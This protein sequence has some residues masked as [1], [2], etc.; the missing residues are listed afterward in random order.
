MRNLPHL[1]VGALLAAASWTAL[2]ERTPP[3]PQALT[4]GPSARVIVQFKDGAS[5]LRAHALSAGSDAFSQQLALSNRAQSLASR[6]GLALRSGAGISERSQVVHGPA[7]MTSQALADQLAADPEVEFAVPDHRMRRLATP[8]DTL[9]PALG[10]GARGPASAQWYLRTPNAEHPASINAQVAWD[11]S[12]GDNVIVAV[13]DTGVRPGHDDL[14]GKLVG[15][16]D[17]V[18]ND[19]G[20]PGAATGPEPSISNDGTGRD[21][22]PSDPGDWLTTAE[23]NADP[24]F[25]QRDVE[26][27]CRASPSSWHG[28]Q[29]AGIVGAATDNGAGMAGTG[30][31]VR[32]M[33]VRVLGKCFGYTSD[34][35]AAMRWA[36]GLSVPNIPDNPNPAH[37]IN[38]SLGGTATCNSG[39]SSA[40]ADITARGVVV[41]AAAGNSAGRA[42][43]APANCAGV[44]GVAGVR[45]VG[46]KVGFSDV[47]PQLAIA[48]PGGNC[49][50]DPAP[51]LYPI[52]S[53]TD[54]GTTTPVGPAYTDAVDFG[55]GTSFS[56]PQV[57]GVVA[58]MLS[59]RAG[60]TPAQIKSALQSSAR[61]FPT[62][63]TDATTGLPVPQCR[64]PNDTDQFEC[65]CTTTTC[66]A[67][68]LDAA[69]AVAA[70][71]G[72]DPGGGG[73]GGGDDDGGG[74]GGGGGAMSAA[75]LLALCAAVAL[76]WRARRSGMPALLLAAGAASLLAPASSH[77]APR[78]D[79]G[80]HG[81]IV[82]LRDAPSHE[83]VARERAQRLNAE[84]AEREAR[85]QARW[86]RVVASLP[87]SSRVTE[88][89]AVGESAQ[90]LRFARPLSR[91]QAQ[92]VAAQ[93]A[94]HDDVSWA[95]PNVRE[96][97]LQTSP[98]ATNAPNDT[99]YNDQWWLKSVVLGSAGVPDAVGAWLARTTGQ[100]RCAG[101]RARQRH[102]QSP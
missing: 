13:L 78:D 92:A 72:L 12:K 14:A 23:L 47:G 21:S 4:D 75:W 53:T 86:Q 52:L 88:R 82:Q 42:A 41:V 97:R 3:R 1:I 84:S 59:A 76:L 31:N 74:G 22:D 38:L 79:A 5:T 81:L 96:R 68:M 27:G 55:V 93:L 6:R 100:R 89:R 62:G 33:P 10:A 7:G 48:A 73:G 58:L 102:R 17:F 83:A 50:N 44:I 90:L 69:G 61:P 99:L 101:G 46:S 65:I 64:A 8:N 49:V 40:I 39:W 36:A 98:A 35:Q 25:W 54:T 24:E 94:R 77:A 18:S 30:W 63:L 26:G 91:A 95:A 15:G 29:V 60:L 32:V 20:N 2:A 28:T 66:G 67:G 16:Y 43:S 9:F 19:P 45:H 85:E 11:S 70:A 87:A 51:C 80:V 71:L 57:A 56:S 34:I 37:V